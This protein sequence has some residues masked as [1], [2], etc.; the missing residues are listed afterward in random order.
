[1]TTIIGI[2]CF[3]L[4]SIKHDNGRYTTEIF[5]QIDQM[6]TYTWEQK[7]VLE[8]KNK[9]LAEIPTLHNSLLQ[10]SYYVLGFLEAFE[11]NFEKSNEYYFK[12]LNDV[13][14]N[15][16]NFCAKIYKELSYNSLALGDEISARYYFDLA[17]EIVSN[18]NDE[19]LKVNLYRRFSQGVIEYTPYHSS[20]I[21]LLELI[22]EENL[23]D[24][25]DLEAHWML[26]T[27]YIFDGYYD[28]SIYHL[29]EAYKISIFYEEGLQRHVIIQLGQ[30]YFLDEQYESAIIILRDCIT[31][32]WT[33]AYMNYIP[34]LA[35]SYRIEEGYSQALQFLDD[36]KSQ[37]WTESMNWVDFWDAYCRA[38][39][40]LNEGDMDSAYQSIEQLN[41]VY[42]QGKELQ[43][44][45]ISLFKDKIELD[46]LVTTGTQTQDIINQY[47]QLY[48][49]IQSSYISTIA[50][51][52]LLD[53]IV[54]KSVNLGHYELGYNYLDARLTHYKAHEQY[55]S[56]IQVN[57][58][59][60]DL[61]KDIHYNDL[62]N[63]LIIEITFLFLF[64][65]ACFLLYVI[66][67]KRLK[68]RELFHQVKV[69]QERDS[70]TN[71]LTQDALY[72]KLENYMAQTTDLSFMVIQVE[73]F[74]SYH[75]KYGYLAEDKL[76]QVLANNIKTIFQEAYVA[77]QEGSRFI[78]VTTYIESMCVLRLEYL[79]EKM[80]QEKEIGLEREIRICY[81][82]SKGTINTR[83]QIDQHI[84]QA[85]S[86]LQSLYQ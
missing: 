10:K 39:I 3:I 7:Q 38:Y 40:A 68:Y 71:T 58:I 37:F 59:Y 4:L 36:Y 51:V 22:L 21:P 62:R 45:S 50:K 84:N 70:L 67:K 44:P 25:N 28:K 15:C 1:M 23:N 54:E 24:Y 69:N 74:K 57:Q 16:A 13:P 65:V 46:Y 35:E 85:I 83:F 6:S 19:E 48:E 75:Q 49:K 14:E 26:A 63:T 78:V 66:W 43:Y 72:E 32:N 61:L 80:E 76:L 11:N 31:E 53:D 79:Q 60:D 12:A 5:Y 47:V 18:T 8:Y 33:T 29:L 30:A 42:E 86:K 27:I 52:T 17:R 55:Q 77:R 9:V 82:L 73:D 20:V 64:A 81:G 34:Q 41:E 2:L 56:T